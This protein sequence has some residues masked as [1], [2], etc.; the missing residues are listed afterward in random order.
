[1]CVC[2]VCVALSK[3]PASSRPPGHNGLQL[4]PSPPTRAAARALAREPFLARA[5]T[6]RRTKQA[7]QNICCSEAAI[8]MKLLFPPS[9]DKVFRCAK[10]P[11]PPTLLCL[12]PLPPPIPFLY[13]KPLIP[14]CFSILH[15]T[16]AFQRVL[17]PPLSSSSSSFPGGAP[18]KSG[19][20]TAHQRLA[21]ISRGAACLQ[22]R[23]ALATDGDL[24]ASHNAF[25]DP[26]K[27]AC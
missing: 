18:A 12:A 14:S 6:R 21:A 19:R 1:M 2:L 17:P 23:S 5:W 15:G 25:C 4:P 22:F 16:P 10:A 3:A 9:N 24:K 27:H 26:S 8:E 20:G 11:P 7:K 13:Q